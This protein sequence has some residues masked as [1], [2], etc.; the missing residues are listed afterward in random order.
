MSDLDAAKFHSLFGAQSPRIAYVRT[1]FVD[2]GLMLLLCAAAVGFVYGPGSW[3]AM[4]GYM[5]CALLFVSFP[6]RHGVA[7][8]VPLLLRRPQDA[9]YMLIYKIRNIRPMYLVAVGILLLD[10]AFIALTPQ[11]PH[12]SQTMRSIVIDLFY[13]HLVVLTIYR[14]IILV[15][16]LRN[17]DTARAVLM[18]TS[19]K[20]VLARQPSMAMQIL[21]AY[22]TGLLTHLVLLAPW[23]LVITHVRY[24][25]ITLPVVLILNFVVFRQYNRTYNLWFYRDHW[26]GHNSELEFLY[27]HGPH[28]DAIPCGLIGVSGNGFLEGIFRHTVGNPMPLYGPIT[29]FLLYSMEVLTDMHSHQYIPGIFPEMPRKFHEQAQ[30]S[31][32]HYGRLEPYGVGLKVDQAGGLGGRSRKLLGYLYPDELRTSYLLDTQLTDFQWDNPR[33][34]RFLELFDKYQK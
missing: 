27:L 19:W 21:H 8:R 7:L 32:H 15:A 6:L 33:H 28:H 11:L 22:F 25:I 10:Q 12:A 23:Y 17:Q 3:L 20:Y 5:F 1:D 9:L 29:A 4:A 14:T 13:I 18:E 2:Y 30:H 24:S 34:K 31:T 26:L 16:Y